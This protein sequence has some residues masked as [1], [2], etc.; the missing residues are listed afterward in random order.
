MRI[1]QAV[2]GVLSVIVALLI[3]VAT[4]VTRGQT[5]PAASLTL[6]ATSVG[7][8]IESD[9]PRAVVATNSPL[10]ANATAPAGEGAVATPTSPVKPRFT[11]TPGSQSPV[12][13]FPTP[14]LESITDEPTPFP[15]PT[16]SS[17]AIFDRPSAEPTPS[18]DPPL[19]EPTPGDDPPL[20]EPTP[21]DEE[22]GI[23][24]FGTP[25][26]GATQ[27]TE[28]ALQSVGREATA[29]PVLCGAAT[30]CRSIYLPL[31]LWAP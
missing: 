1:S 23:D 31:T 13:A 5:T 24:S 28:P 26:I 12:E 14:T 9:G 10:P 7:R 11:A 29:T 2:G 17:E 19:A 30:P 18:D 16:E 27:T 8:P 4:H 6:T 21:G 15:T 22:P 3:V 20:A 25:T